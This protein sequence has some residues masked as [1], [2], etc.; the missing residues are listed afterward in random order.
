M[1]EAPRKPNGT[2]AA[3]KVFSLLRLSPQSLA[4]ALDPG[5]ADKNSS[6]KKGEARRTAHPPTAYP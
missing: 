4:E 1:V 6:H 3:L 5:R 2:A